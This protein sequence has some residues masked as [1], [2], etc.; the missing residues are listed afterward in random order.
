MHPI[1]TYYMKLPFVKN[2]EFHFFLCRH[3]HIAPR[4]MSLYELAFRHRS[5]SLTLEDGSIVNNERLEYLGDAVLDTIVATYL[6]KKFPD[7]QEGF[8]TQVRSKLVQRSQLGQ[9]GL[10]MGL[11]KFITKQL[12]HNTLPMKHLCGDAFEAL[13][14]ALYLD[15]GYRK[16]EHYVIGF[17]FKRYVQLDVVMQT[18]TDF[19][20]RLIEWTQ[21]NRLKLTI[22]IPDAPH[23]PNDKRSGSVFVATVYIG[24][25]EVAKGTGHSKKTAEQHAAENALHA[26]P[27][28]PDFSPEALEHYL[29][30]MTPSTTH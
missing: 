30:R 28:M 20:S 14:G 23:R 12:G 16:T 4:Q 7:K 9:L 10:E 13:I 27:T 17:I 3:L 15:R 26:I 8:L 11:D 18:E 5:A 6:F 22:D 21:K 24:D 19:K 1:L 29:D 2:K 25:M